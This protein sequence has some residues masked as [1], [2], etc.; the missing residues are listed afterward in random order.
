M[1][2]LK[3]L[4]DAPFIG[5]PIKS[6]MR[7]LVNLKIRN[8]SSHFSFY[9]APQIANDPLLLDKVF[10]MRHDVYCEELHFLEETPDKRERDSFDDHAWH[11]M[12]QHKSTKDFAGTVRMVYSNSPDELLPLEKFCPDSIGEDQI[13]P[14]NFR[15]DEICEI[16]RLA[17]PAHFRRRNTD[18][19]KGAATGTINQDSYSEKELRCFPFIAVGLY[20]TAAS[21][22][23]DSGREHCFVMMEPRLA[24]SLRLVGISF[25]QIG[26]A[27]EYHGR[28]APYYINGDLLMRSLTP[29]F[30]KMLKNIRRELHRQKMQDP[31]LRDILSK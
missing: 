1:R 4:A 7:H 23:L 29:G 15:R 5:K 18:N 20:L 25:I 27:I 2:T 9:F 13:H 21:M 28:R 30:Q 10:S 17:V 16:S 31:S 6:V 8:I 12:L 22:A 24:R 11:C 14:D 3:K 19:V 26:P